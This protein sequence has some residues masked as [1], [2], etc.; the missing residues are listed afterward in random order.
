M[1]CRYENHGHCE[2]H[3]RECIPASQGCIIKAARNVT[4]IKDTGRLSG[5]KGIST[6]SD[7]MV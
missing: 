5:D 2:L 6:K 4:L 7:K 1:Y 3:K